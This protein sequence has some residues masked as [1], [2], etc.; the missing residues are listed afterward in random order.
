M[1]TDDSFDTEFLFVKKLKLNQE[2]LKYIFLK[3]KEIN[4]LKE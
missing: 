3:S 2:N 1:N 4:Y